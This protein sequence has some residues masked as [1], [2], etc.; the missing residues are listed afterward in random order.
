MPWHLGAPVSQGNSSCPGE[1]VEQ[2]DSSQHMLSAQQVSAGRGGPGSSTSRRSKTAIKVAQTL[3]GTRRFGWVV[4]PGRALSGAGP[5]P[6]VPRRD[7]VH[8]SSPPLTPGSGGTAAGR[9]LLTRRISVVIRLATSRTLSAAR[10]PAPGHRL[11]GM[12]RSRLP[13]DGRGI[14]A[15][16][17]ASPSPR[18]RPATGTEGGR[19]EA[20]PGSARGRPVLP[21][22]EGKQQAAQTAGKQLHI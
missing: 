6:E 16:R 11:Q 22:L 9:I 1:H 8:T 21:S 2:R 14:E 3:C 17:P 12:S 20:L 15:P 4:A 18:R 7:A 10:S 19:R 5:G 13:L